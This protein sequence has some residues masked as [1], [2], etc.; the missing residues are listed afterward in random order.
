MKPKFKVEATAMISGKINRFEVHGNQM[1]D[2]NQ[3]AGF[4]LGSATKFNIEETKKLFHLKLRL[5]FQAFDNVQKNLNYKATIESAFSFYV[6]NL[7]DFAVKQEKNGALYNSEL[8]ITLAGMAYSTLRGM[9]MYA[10]K[11]TPLDGYI[12]PI[13]D[14]SLLV[15][16]E[17]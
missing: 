17:K 2:R 5:T 14:P 3:I 9:L 11:G 16:L 1:L 4:D 6:E 13:V 10:S 12:I 7:N 15:H 8:A